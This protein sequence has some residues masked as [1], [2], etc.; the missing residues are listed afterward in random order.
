MTDKPNVM[1]MTVDQQRLDAAAAPALR[2]EIEAS[3]DHSPDRVLIDLSQVEFIDST[4]LGVL[5][6]LLKRMNSGGKI[7]VLGAKAPVRRL[8]QITRLDSLFALCD[9]DEDAHAALS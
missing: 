3:L 9:S 5:V 1:R 6:M 4:G 8:F 7:A 2:A